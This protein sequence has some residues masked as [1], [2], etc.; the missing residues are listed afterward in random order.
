[1]WVSSLDLCNDTN[2]KRG[3]KIIL[4]VPCASQ[5]TRLRTTQYIVLTYLGCERHVYPCKG[6]RG[7]MDD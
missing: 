2:R 7:K 5:Y 4:F 3:D 1:M 6:V